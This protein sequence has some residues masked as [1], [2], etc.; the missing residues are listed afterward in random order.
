MMLIH[1]TECLS[2]FPL[3]LQKCTSQGGAATV[4]ANH[5]SS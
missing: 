5:V 1:N 4:Q 3:C 2:D